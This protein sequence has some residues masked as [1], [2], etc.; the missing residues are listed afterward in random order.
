[1]DSKGELKSISTIMGVLGDHMK[2]LSKADKVDIMNS[3]FGTTG[4]QAGLI[5]AENAK[6]LGKLSAETL[7]AGK[8]GKYVSELASKNSQTAKVQ[9]DRFKQ[10]MNAFTM[11]LGSAFLPAINEAGNKMAKFLTSKD[12]QKFQK[13]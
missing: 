6:D 9:M 1:M 5:L 8:S 11:D 7:K 13:M 10:T 4:Q 2:G 3:L 12:G